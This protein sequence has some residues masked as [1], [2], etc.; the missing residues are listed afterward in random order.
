MMIERR[1]ARAGFTLTRDYPVPLE[2]V[3]GNDVGTGKTPQ[4][5]HGKFCRLL[6]RAYSSWRCQQPT[7]YTYD[8]AGIG[9]PGQRWGPFLRWHS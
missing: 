7:S 9:L 2:R 1:L 8:D 6:R 3:A 4:W 5:L